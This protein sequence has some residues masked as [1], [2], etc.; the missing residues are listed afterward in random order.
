MLIC[1]LAAGLALS[2]VAIGQVPAEAE[3]E[4][5]INQVREG[6]FE[7][8]VITLDGVVGALFAQPR[9]SEHLSRAYIYLGIA[10]ASLGQQE[11][12]KEQLLKAWQTDRRLTLSSHEFPPGIIG[13][14]EQVRREAEEKLG[15]EVAAEPPTAEASPGA[16]VTEGKRS[17]SKLP[18]VLLGGAAALGGGAA[19][20]VLGGSSSESAF[21]PTPIPTPEPTPCPRTSIEL[22]DASPP[23]GSTISV[24][25]CVNDAPCPAAP[26]FRFR[27]TVD[28]Y[29]RYDGQ[30]VDTFGVFVGGC[31]KKYVSITT[32]LCGSQDV[33]VGDMIGTCL[34]RLEWE[35][36]FSTESV[37]AELYVGDVQVLGPGWYEHYDMAYHFVP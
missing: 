2:A 17:G 19:I 33:V 35:G 11:K 3:L 32:A 8:A 30:Y 27:L 4:K 26:R 5:G 9:Q 1:L 28:P 13:L 16:V 15:A 25:G 36:S 34:D 18:L 29:M 37:R 10:Y 14:Y 20:A 7:L 24:G 12:G 22:L 31:F 21:T 23:S 6:E